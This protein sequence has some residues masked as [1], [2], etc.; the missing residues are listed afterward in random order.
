[1]TTHIFVGGSPYLGSDSVFG[2]KES[3]IAD[4]AVVDDGDMAA[5]HGMPVPVRHAHVELRLRSAR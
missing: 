5:E 4:F 2:V 3:L 1:M